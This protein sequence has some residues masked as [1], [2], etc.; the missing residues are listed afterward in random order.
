MKHSLVCIVGGGFS[1]ALTAINLARHDGPRAILIERR[2]EPG[3]GVAYSA[4][5]PDHLLNVR[6][7]N[8]SAFPDQPGHF[9]AWLERTGNGTGATFVPRR[10]YGQYLTSIILE[11][12]KDSP[13]RLEIVTDEALR[14]TEHGSSIRPLLA[15]GA[16]LD[17]DA[18][19]L[20]LGNL[21][22]HPP[23]GLDPDSV[24]ADT[25]E[26]NP[27][28]GRVADDLEKNDAVLLVGTGL[29]MVDAALLISK[30]SDAKIVALSRR[31]LLPRAHVDGLPPANRMHRPPRNATALLCDVRRRAREVDWRVAVDELRPH[32]QAVW[33]AATQETRQR[34]LRHLRPWWDVHRHRLAPDVARQLSELV[35]SGR[36]VVE[37]GKICEFTFKDKAIDV[38]WRP[39]GQ[40]ALAGR[41]FRR[42]VNCTGPQGDLRRS[43]EPLLQQLLQDGLIRPDSNNIGLDV[44]SQA[45]VIS[46]HGASAARLYAVGPMT[47]GE[48]WE[49]VA[50]PDIRHQVW[51]LARRL[52]NAHWVEGEGL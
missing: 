41:T 22:P 13:G 34:F 39:R 29:T 12:L 19:V 17:C 9:T 49:I 44:D 46:A 20:A 18:A 2:H 5:Q 4:E 16:H 25:Y 43:N 33:G 40:S 10:V 8:M 28:S 11:I 3:R 48:F 42:I 15:S 52:S 36:L 6:A 1:G 35:S 37:A 30:R 7:G 45:R 27:W 38:L 23:A 47:R 24:S 51:T 14:L 32:T 31:G 26:P 21:P 50:V